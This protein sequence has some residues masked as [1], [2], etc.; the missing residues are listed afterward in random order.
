[1]T[2]ALMELM[3]ERGWDDIDVLTLCERADI[4]RSTFYEHFRNKEELL[5]TSFAGLKSALLEHAASGEANGGVLGFVPG[6]VAHVHEAQGVF[7]ALLKRR[8]GHYVQD[9]FREL[10]IELILAAEPATRA[11]QWQTLARAHYL[12]GALFEM[13]VWW[14]GSNRPH[15]PHEIESLYRRWSAAVLGSGG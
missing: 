12:A 4:G 7:R 5:K 15:K 14:L 3:V 9:R 11:Q 2:V 8:S 10:L 6:L 1:M 13:L